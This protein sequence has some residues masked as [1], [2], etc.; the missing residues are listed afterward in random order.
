MIDVKLAARGAKVELARRHFY[1]YCRLMYPTGYT[2]DRVYLRRI[3]EEL[4]AFENQ[5]K[6]HYL[7]LNV[8]PRHLKSFT[9]QNFTE[10]LFG[11]DPTKKI[12]TASY[13]ETLATIFAKKVRNTIRT[14]KGGNAIV[15]KDVFPNVKIKFGDAS[16]SLWGL[17]GSG[18]NNY[19]ATSPTGTFTGLGVNRLII[20]DPL[21][22]AEEAYNQRVLD[23]IWD[24]FNN[25]CLSRLEGDDYKIYI[26]MTRWAKDDLAGRII[27]SYG[28]DVRVIAYRAVQDDGTMLCPSILSRRAFDRKTQEMNPDIVEA[29]YNQMPIDVKGRLY[30]PFMEWDVLPE[31]EVYN[32]TD[33]ADRGKDYL[34]S[35]NY[36]QHGEDVYIT[37]LVYTDESMEKT[38][39]EVAEMLHSGDVRTARIESN[40]GGR[41][42]ARNVERILKNELHNSRVVIETPAQ[43]KNKESRILASSGWIQRH[44]FM[45]P[46]WQ[47]KWPQAA[48]E[49]LRYQRKGVNAHD[50]LCDVLAA[51]YEA[52][53]GDNRRIQ[54][55]DEGANSTKDPRIRF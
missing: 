22:S 12:A 38:E 10:H 47:K 9:A 32:I 39:H 16:A 37:D 36:I 42:F 19:L 5:T 35:A 18:E 3:C 7:V 55:L 29:N 25:T 20:D 2:D 33:T 26:I 49:V 43:T 15:Y 40:N 41:G 8:P 34:A 6:Q 52:V 28:D 31:G 23:D 53:T 21:K 44:L 30:E 48:N 11:K 54:F 45:P 4:E 1:D 14:P 24:W 27:D 13:N 50:D 46:N 51:I 17:E